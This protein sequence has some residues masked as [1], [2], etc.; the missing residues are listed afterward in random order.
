METTQGGERSASPE[1]LLGEAVE[2]EEKQKQESL[3]EM[4]ARHRD[5]VQKLQN[6]EISFKKEAAKGSKAEQKAKKKQV[7]DEI[8]RL[9][10]QLKSKHSQEL[11]SLGYQTA[12]DVVKAISGVTIL[13]KMNPPNRARG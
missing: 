9:T 12:D 10:A 4:L 1:E 13:A 3:E 6:K 11:A 8:S 5:E 2:E 7:E